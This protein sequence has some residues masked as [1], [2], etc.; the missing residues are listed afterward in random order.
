VVSI[1]FFV[2]DTATSSHFFRIGILGGTGQL[3]DADLINFVVRKVSARSE[4]AGVMI[5]L[6]SLPPPRTLWDKLKGGLTYLFRLGGFAFQRYNRYFL[7]SNTAHMN[8]GKFRLLSGFSDVFH[9]PDKVAKVIRKSREGVTA[10]STVLILG[11]E[12]SWQN[13]FYSK[14]L[15]KNQI[16]AK[17]L[18][19]KSMKQLQ[20][21]I[22]LIKKRPLSFEEETEFAKFVVRV[23]KEHSTSSVLLGCTEISLGLGEAINTLNTKGI[24]VF[25]S[26]KIFVDEIVSTA[27]NSGVNSQSYF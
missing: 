11:T 18:D 13:K 7:A 14:I 6:F 23:S 12:K 9:L 19:L 2:G 8:Y 1:K 5:H 25:D 4:G 22:N 17:R 10:S 27:Q 21:W 24:D 26:G 3:S 20:V 15:E 16:P